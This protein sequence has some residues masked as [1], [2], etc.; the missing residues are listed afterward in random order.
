MSIDDKFITDPEEL[1]CAWS[2]YFNQQCH[3]QLAVNE[4]LKTTHQK[5][6]D[7]EAG[8]FWEPNEVFDTSIVLW[9]R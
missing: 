7:I 4:S 1:L 6:K 2:S 9:K 5:F 3:S 8:S